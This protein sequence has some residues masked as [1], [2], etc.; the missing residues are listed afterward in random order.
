MVMLSTAVWAGKSQPLHPVPEMPMA[1]A[2]SLKDI[3]GE[4]YTSQ[5]YLGKVV[6]VNFWTTWCPPC[7]DE[8]PSMERAYRQFKTQGIEILAINVGED[9]DTIFTFT[10]DYPVTFPLLMDLDSKVINQ[11]PVIGLPTTYI[12]DTKGRLVYK[13]IGT[14]EWD[15]PALI[16]QILNLKK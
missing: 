11:Y 13:A 10:V 6:I 16:Q 3:N 12:I 15:N 2:F 5:D 4:L 14:R 7:R 1:P 8:L 9:A